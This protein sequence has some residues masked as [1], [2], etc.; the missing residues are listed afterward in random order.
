MH[1]F[2]FFRLSLHIDQIITTLWFDR[3]VMQLVKLTAL[4]QV[5]IETG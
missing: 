1:D 3:Q 2:R 5:N 4:K